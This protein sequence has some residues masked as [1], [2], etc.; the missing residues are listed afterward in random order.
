MCRSC[1]NGL[2]FLL[3]A[4]VG[5]CDISLAIRCVLFA[6]SVGVQKVRVHGVLLYL[7]L[8]VVFAFLWCRGDRY[9]DNETDV[10]MYDMS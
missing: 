1:L 5:S 9:I 3:D 8:G 4:F 6:L 10:D 2:V 7:V